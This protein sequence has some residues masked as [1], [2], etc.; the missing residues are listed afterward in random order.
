MRLP[1][2][3]AY[4]PRRA[5]TGPKRGQEQ[6]RPDNRSEA[7]ATLF[8]GKRRSKPTRED[9]E[10]AFKEQS[11]CTHARAPTPVLC[12]CLHTLPH[13]YADTCTL[14]TPLLPLSVS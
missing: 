2:A 12:T 13:V 11:T 3:R 4:L 14:T 7:I 9:W 5:E 8:P 10:R 6:Q 1:A